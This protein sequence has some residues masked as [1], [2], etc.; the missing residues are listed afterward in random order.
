MKSR[1]WRVAA[2]VAV[3]GVAATLLALSAGRGREAAQ[4]VR[5]TLG[6][7]RDAP[8]GTAVTKQVASATATTATFGPHVASG[9]F[10][11]VSVPV[12]SLPVTIPAIVTQLNPRDSENLGASKGSSNAKD[13]VIQKKRGGGPLSGPLT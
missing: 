3:L 8:E 10:V 6:V 13:P 9:K 12:S 4:P 11:G 7:E 5:A 1:T 2:V